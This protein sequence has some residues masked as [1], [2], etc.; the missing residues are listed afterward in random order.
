MLLIS[1]TQ[2]LAAQRIFG[3]AERDMLIREAGVASLAHTCCGFIGRDLASIAEMLL[4]SIVLTF[5]YWPLSSSFVSGSDLFA[6]GFALIYAVWGFSHILAIAFNRQVA[7][8]ASVLVS[9]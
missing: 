5:T 3:A 1:L 6:I 7:L 8:I 9:F 4:A 2:T